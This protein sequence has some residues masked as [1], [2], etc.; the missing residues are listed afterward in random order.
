MNVSFHALAHDGH[1]FCVDFRLVLLVRSL[2]LVEVLHYWLL[3]VLRRGWLRGRV[4]DG[5][6]GRAAA[7][8]LAEVWQERGDYAETLRGHC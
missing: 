6:G 2:D 3:L 8:G 1:E 5:R 4:G 7:K